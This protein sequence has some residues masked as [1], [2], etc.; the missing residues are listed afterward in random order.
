MFR[1]VL[2]ALSLSAC[3]T[4]HDPAYDLWGCDG[5]PEFCADRPAA[6][7]PH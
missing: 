3:T 5:I 1:I 4:V 6:N 7:D 2:I